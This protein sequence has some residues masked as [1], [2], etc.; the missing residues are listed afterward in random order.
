VP[1]LESDLS[2]FPMLSAIQKDSIFEVCI[3]RFQ[4]GP[5][6]GQ[7]E[8]SIGE[9]CDGYFGRDLTKSELLAL[10]EEIKRFAEF[11]PIKT[12]DG[13]TSAAG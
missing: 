1:L 2:A 10:A 7:I 8:F 12:K 11:P 5:R 9:L 6:K 4:S 3:H 13:V